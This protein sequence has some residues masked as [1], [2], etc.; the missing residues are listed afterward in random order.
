MRKWMLIS[1]LA[2]AGCGENLGWNPNYTYNASAYGQYKAQRERT[3]V[4]DSDPAAT[5]PVALPAQSPTVQQ[6]GRVNPVPVP[7]VPQ[8]R[9]RVVTTAPATTTGQ[10]IAIATPVATAGAATSEAPLLVRYA[11]QSQQRPGTAVYSRNNPQPQQA[12]A[13]CASFATSAAA[14][15]AF[16]EAGGPQSDPRGMDPDGDGFVCGWDPVPYRQPQL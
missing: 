3:L 5:I 6:I 14:Q 11:V 8:V 1:V 15:T 2:L 16:L 13:I 4:T 12:G 7:P 9:R 10:P